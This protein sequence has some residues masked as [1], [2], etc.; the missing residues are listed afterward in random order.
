[1]WKARSAPYTYTWHTHI[2]S[3]AT[4]ALIFIPCGFAAGIFWV[5]QIRWFS[6]MFT[7]WPQMALVLR[8]T[9]P[10]HTWNPTKPKYWSALIG[11]TIRIFWY[12][13]LTFKQLQ[14]KPNFAFTLFSDLRPAVTRWSVNLSTDG[15]WP[16]M[17]LAYGRSEVPHIHM[18]TQHVSRRPWFLSSY[19]SMLYRQ[20]FKH[21]LWMVQDSDVWN[22]HLLW[23]M[24]KRSTSPPQ[25]ASRL[26]HPN[27]PKMT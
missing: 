6:T 27:E 17:T 19:V 3:K 21:V 15:K 23:S 16:Q 24:I 13:R 9:I 11:S 14:P 25:A 12:Y 26:R 1:M 8:S 20:I 4:Y 22:C 5:L 18:R 2:P 7:E 10:P